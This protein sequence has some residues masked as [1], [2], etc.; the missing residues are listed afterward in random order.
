MAGALHGASRWLWPCRRMSAPAAASRCGGSAT[1]TSLRV[2]AVVAAAV[3]A[4]GAPGLP[5]ARQSH[6]CASLGLVTT[7]WAPALARSG[8]SCRSNAHDTV[9]S[10]EP[11]TGRAGGVACASSGRRRPH[12]HRSR[13]PASGL[14]A[15]SFSAVA[16]VAPQ[17]TVFAEAQGAAQLEADGHPDAAAREWVR[18]AEICESAVGA[19]A[20]MT[21]S[22][23]WR[24]ANA[25]H[26]C[27]NLR[28]GEAVVQQL[29]QSARGAA[30]AGAGGAGEPATD[31]IHALGSACALYLH[32]N[33]TTRARSFAQ[34]LAATARATEHWG[35]AVIA[36]NCLGL[37]DLADASC[38]APNASWSDKHFAAA[39]SIAQ[40]KGC[41]AAAHAGT[42]RNRAVYT[43]LYDRYIRATKPGGSDG[44][45]AGPIGCF[46]GRAP[47]ERLTLAR[48][49]L[50]DAV[51]L[52]PTDEASA[53]DNDVARAHTLMALGSVELCADHVDLAY[54]SLSDAMKLQERSTGT[55]TPSFALTLALLGVVHHAM[56]QAVTA[57][58]L[59]RASLDTFGACRWLQPVQQRAHRL[60]LLWYSDLLADWEDRES[61]ASKLAQRAAGISVAPASDCPPPDV[62]G[63]ASRELAS[64]REFRAMPSFLTAMPSWRLPLP[65]L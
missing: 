8:V 37:C 49:M 7:Q 42:L 57:E 12:Q 23:L 2:A 3:P 52:L 39:L 1:A 15:R 65:P 58:G 48:K 16:K 63:S 43:A 22:A 19:V 62:G 41:N 64:N 28:K 31:L 9:G 59:F 40:S 13:D 47:S 33:D 44:T 34:E 27:A 53:S 17:L 20:P 25:Y 54:E 60:S 18:V 10:R 30:S 61:E 56:Q 26:S 29:L 35:A 4:V 24:V 51:D 36:A 11:S 14:H 38:G 5:P 55:Q 46:N 50:G 32:V 21:Q 6:S 45:P